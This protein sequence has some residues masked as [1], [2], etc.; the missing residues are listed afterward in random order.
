MA[1]VGEPQCV[2][3]KDESQNDAD[4]TCLLRYI[5][6]LDMTTTFVFW[7]NQDSLMGVDSQPVPESGCPAEMLED[8]HD[9][10]DEA[11]FF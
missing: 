10:H 6:V 1:I 7:L 4:A 5:W 8:K 3:V 9:D 2:V 11:Q